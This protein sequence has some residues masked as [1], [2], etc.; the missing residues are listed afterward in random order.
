MAYFDDTNFYH[1]MSAAEDI[2]LNPSLNLGPV[3]QEP[4]HVEAFGNS[5]NYW[6]MV[7]QPGPLVDPLTNVWV[8]NND[9]KDP[10]HRLFE[11]C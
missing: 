11:L 1:I 8:P 4:N 5:E 6:D 2:N 9:S 10:Y 3:A 7:E